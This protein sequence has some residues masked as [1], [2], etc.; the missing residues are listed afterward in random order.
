M[1]ATTRL[2]TVAAT[3]A[4]VAAAALATP[5][6]AAASVTPEGFATA[7]QNL[8]HQLSARLDQLRQLS[9]DVTKATTLTTGDA[10]TLAARLAAATT[11]MTTLAAQVPT[12]TTLAELRAA[13]VTMIRDNRVY[14][15][16]TPQV[17]EVIEADAVQ[18]QVQTLQA[19]EP[20]LQSAVENLVGQVGYRAATARDQ[21]FV[22]AVDRASALASRVSLTVLA[23]TPRDFPRDVSV[24]LHANR[25]LLNAEIA[26]AHA[27]YNQSLVGLASGGYTGS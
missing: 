25:Q 5:A 8:E 22:V 14:A 26:L 1:R 19:D 6:V 10:S 27:S 11:S 16:L 17:F 12:D 9:A 21:A 13:R 3:T 4:L 2:R 18:S 23:Q 24:F 7:Q 15:V 20:A